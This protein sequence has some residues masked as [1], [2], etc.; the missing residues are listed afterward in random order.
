MYGMKDSYN[1]IDE[2]LEDVHNELSVKDTLIA[3]GEIKRDDFHGQLINCVFHDNDHTPSLQIT[4][5]FFK[6]YSGRCNAKGDLVEFIRIRHDLD[7]MDAVKKV[8]AY[9]NVSLPNVRRKYDGVA[10]RLKN[11]WDRYLKE[12]DDAPEDVKSVRRE[13]FPQ[14]VGYDQSIDY[15]VMPFTSRSGSILGFTKRRLHDDILL[16][17]NGEKRPKWKHSSAA[18]TLIGTCHNIFNLSVASGEIR[19]RKELILVEGPKDVIGYRRINRPN[20]ICSCGTSNVDNVWDAML[21]VGSIVLSHDGDQ[22]GY[23]ATI[24][25][26]VFLADKVDIKTV[27]AVEMPDNEDPYSVKNL[28]E[29]YQNRIPVVDFV[30]KHGSDMEIRNLY[31]AVPNWNSSAVL[32]AICNGKMLTVNEA[33]DWIDFVPE[34]DDKGDE[35]LSEKDKLLAVV[36]CRDVNVPYIPVDKAK[37]IL[38]MKYNIKL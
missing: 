4:D 21:P 9:L 38:A 35:A 34:K 33:L 32:K 8:A 26:A 30:V 6:C 3:M 10:N 25:A 1:E 22:A 37:R 29:C 23:S 11:E 28:E 2:F 7:F 16:D 14:E 36:E 12:M 19:K 5:N 17:A 31:H 24:N 18:Y 13:F 20:V 15:V 27:T